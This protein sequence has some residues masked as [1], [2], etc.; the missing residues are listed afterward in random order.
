MF[1]ANFTLNNKIIKYLNRIAEIRALIDSSRILPKQ[2]IVLKRRAAI[3]MAQSSTSIEGNILNQNEVSRVF[4]G[5][6]IFAPKRDEI[7]V[8]NYQKALN[9]VDE[10]L[11]SRR[12]ITPQFILELHRILMK[13]LLPEEK[14]GRFRKGPVYVVNINF[15]P[16]KDELIYRS[17]KAK[18]VPRHIIDLLAWV[19]KTTKEGLSPVVQA[20]IIHYQMATIHPFPDGNGRVAR[21]LTAY[22]L[23]LTGLEMKK[24]CVLDSFYNQDRKRYYNALDTGKDY[25]QRIG[26]D[27]TP[28]LEY[29]LEGF[30][31]ELEK[32]KEQLDILK[33]SP[34]KKEDIFL[35][36]D[37]VRI[38]DF[39]SNLGKITSQDVVDILKVSKRASQ[40][41][42]KKLVEIGI[43]KKR[44]KGPSSFYTPSG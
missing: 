19:E 31:A 1:E 7:E 23:Y 20:G 29:F 18:K 34:K 43:L 39:V 16:R 13:D 24:I 40:M 4:R 33:F 26:V 9:F 37:E 21:L 28:W 22:H 44:G 36:Q 32:I 27:L 3:R 6:K 8:K 25:N 14:L 35:S 5:E 41:K 42:L 2:E 30:A 17:P 11:K 10:S 15:K 12:K 38:V